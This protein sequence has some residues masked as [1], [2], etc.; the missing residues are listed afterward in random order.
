[1]VSRLPVGLCEL[2]LDFA[3][4]DVTDD[5]LRALARDLPMSVT[6]L[7]LY[8]SGS[9]VTDEGVGALAERLPGGVTFLWLEF[10]DT[11]VTVGSLRALGRRLGWCRRVQVRRERGARSRRGASLRWKG[12]VDVH[13]DV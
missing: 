8:F 3:Y 4:S 2:T 11:A 9:A 10:G 1:M 13:I 5:G 7:I 12:G 6:R